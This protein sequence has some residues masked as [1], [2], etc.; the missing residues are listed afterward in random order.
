MQAPTVITAGRATIQFTIDHI[1][2]RD[3]HR[4][5]TLVGG[6]VGRMVEEH[7]RSFATAEDATDWA[8]MLVAY[9]N[10]IPDSPAEITPTIDVPVLRTPVAAALTNLRIAGWTV[11]K[12]AA[13]LG[14]TRGAVYR[15]RRGGTPNPRNL[16]KLV[17]LSESLA[18]HGA[19]CGCRGYGCVQVTTNANP[20]HGRCS[21]NPA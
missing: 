11:A 6:P 7:T 14:V 16:A 18:A 19:G 21:C 15:W 5:E 20:V 13:E 10:P 12:I 1:A 2:G 3:I 8:A 9:Y 4:V 17:D